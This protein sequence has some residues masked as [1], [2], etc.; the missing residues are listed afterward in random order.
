[1]P[2]RKRTRGAARSI[3]VTALGMKILRAI[4]RGRYT[5]QKTRGGRFRPKQSVP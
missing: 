4:E 1:M 2:P 3:V 5:F